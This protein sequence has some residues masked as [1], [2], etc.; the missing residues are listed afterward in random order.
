[1]DDAK[2]VIKLIFSV[3][4]NNK[5]I[6]HSF[7]GEITNLHLVVRALPGES[8]DSQMFDWHNLNIE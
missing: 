6:L 4:A 2:L 1:M 3:K 7:K 8:F 5:K